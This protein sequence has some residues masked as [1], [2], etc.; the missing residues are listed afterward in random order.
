LLLGFL[1]F[2]AWIYEDDLEDIKI[3]FLDCYSVLNI[4][5]NANNQEIRISYKELMLQYH[6]DKHKGTCKECHEKIVV[7]NY[8]FSTLNDG[9]KRSWYDHYHPMAGVIMDPTTEI[10]MTDTT[11][12]KEPK[13]SSI[14]SATIEP[15]QNTES[16]TSAGLQGTQQ[17]T[18]ALYKNYNV[19]SLLV[20]CWDLAS[21]WAETAA[22]SISD[23]FN[24]KLRESDL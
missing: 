2:G 7:L 13:V 1:I 15:T 18:T 4:S 20:W 10:K 3:T 11:V 17:E 14:E 21:G 8:A 19:F 5:R 22:T 9:R 12:A 6:P 16:A 24:F 23:F